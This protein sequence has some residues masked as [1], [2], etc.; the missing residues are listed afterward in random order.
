MAADRWLTRV[1]D[2]VG[3]LKVHADLGP[4]VPEVGRPEIRH[5]LVKPYR[6]VYR[7]DPSVLVVLTLRHTR[8]AWDPREISEG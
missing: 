6:I 8:R 7:R 2:R 3:R 4:P 1:L 5:I